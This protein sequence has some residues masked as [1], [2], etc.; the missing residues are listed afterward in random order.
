MT[1]VARE[2]RLRPDLQAAARGDRAA[3]GRVVMACQSTVASVALAVVRDVHTSEDIAQEAF[4]KGWRSLDSLSNPDSFLPWLRQITRNLARD[5][6][7]AQKYRA[8][9]VDDVDTLIARAA[10]PAPDPAERHALEQEQALA[11]AAIDALPEESREVLLLYY[12]EGQ[13]SRQVASLL[14]LQDA[15][16]RKRLQRARQTIRAELLA[17]LGEFARSSAPSAAFTGLVVGALAVATPTAAAA[18]VIGAAGAGKT[19]GKVLLGSA[20]SLAIGLLA[21][22]A[23]LYWGLRCQLRGAIDQR[24][25]T[26]LTRSALINGATTVLFILGIIAASAWTRG[27]VAPVAITLVFMGVIL[28][29]SMRVQPRIL[30]RRHA[31][32]A[33]R[34]PQGAARRRRRERINSWLGLVVGVTLGGGSLIYALISSG[35]L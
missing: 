24:E 5:H 17:R 25:R 31:L 18:G 35:R 3:Y 12:R 32:E 22:F 1:A 16:V 13:N 21:T 11:A 34:D 26:A 19:F 2:T 9:P 8:N 27:W 10:D 28:W 7:R 4:L 33:A 30:A 14:G 6:L 20:G 15:A 29:Q 23:A